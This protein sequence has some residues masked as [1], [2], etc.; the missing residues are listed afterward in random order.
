MSDTNRKTL[1]QTLTVTTLA[2]IL[3][4]ANTASASAPIRFGH[5]VNEAPQIQPAAQPL[6]QYASAT[7]TARDFYYPDET[8]PQN[9][10]SDERSLSPEP[11][12]YSTEAAV[13]T[14]LVSAP[15]SVSPVSTNIPFIAPDVYASYVKIGKPYTINGV[16][17]T[18]AAD[19]F[20]DNTGTASWYGEQFH[21]K[22]TANGE[23]YDMHDMSAAHPTLPI[24]S[25]VLVTNEEN[26]NEVVV[27]INDRGPFKKDRIIDMSF[28]AATK[29]D[30][31]KHGTAKVR[32]KYLGP[33]EKAGELPLT[34]H[35]NEQKNVQPQAAQLVSA[36]TNGHFVQ[37]ASFASRDN[38]DKFL[39]KATNHSNDADIVF[40]KVNG[41]D[42]FRVVLGPYASKSKA[43]NELENMI[44]HGFEGYVMQNP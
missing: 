30:M 5:D 35:V 33:A 38:A 41:Q 18:P 26:G 9:N 37:L 17:Y 36:Q 21:G 44:G 2:L 12:K 42:R 23:I 16:T 19:P 27:R 15:T 14:A 6:K 10:R 20:Y 31:I 1:R 39:G 4:A 22:L 25:Y 28:A 3:T 11:I 8:I 32:V 29:L 24:P 43:Q 40:K 13:K 34:Q 7:T